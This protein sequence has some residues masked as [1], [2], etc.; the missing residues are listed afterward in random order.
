MQE[1]INLL[2]LP[3]VFS[4]PHDK[5]TLS[6]YVATTSMEEFIRALA[7]GHPRWNFICQSPFT[8]TAGGEWVGRCG[9][10]S[11]YDGSEML[12]VVRAVPT[13]T[14]HGFV[15]MFTVASQRVVQDTKRSAV[16]RRAE[17][18]KSSN[19]KTALRNARKYLR[20][21]NPLEAVVRIHNEAVTTLRKK[22]A[23]IQPALNTLLREHLDVWMAM[24][25]KHMED[26]MDI[27]RRS[28]KNP[29]EFA[30]LPNEIGAYQ[31]L[32]GVGECLSTPREVVVRIRG[33][34]YALFWPHVGK[35]S[36]CIHTTDTLPAHIK[37][38]LGLLK[39][40]QVGD[41]LRDV[42]MR[43]TDNEYVLTVAE[44]E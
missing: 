38:G 10:F 21:E 18:V 44:D 3:N 2:G 23:S 15:T 19:L 9:M 32:K 1:L 12:G 4:E 22:Q 40:V 5:H 43:V 7:V 41:V 39:L 25:E 28:G 29:L 24:C 16:G 14:K 33:N 31:V 37:R 36:L 26:M 11:V 6:R 13:A 34:D 8:D 35:E 20:P 17:T 30:N 42:G 27:V